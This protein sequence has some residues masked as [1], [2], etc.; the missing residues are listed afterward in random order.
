M[1][2]VGR[3]PS[4]CGSLVNWSDNDRTSRKTTDMLRHLPVATVGTF[5]L[6]GVGSRSRSPPAYSRVL[7]APAEKPH[8]RSMRRTAVQD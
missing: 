7:P 3:Q 6:P 5:L 1:I 8:G 2:E 4:E